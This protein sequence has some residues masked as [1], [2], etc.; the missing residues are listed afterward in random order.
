MFGLILGVQVVKIAEELV[1]PV[2]GRSSRRLAKL[3]PL[4]S[5]LEPRSWGDKLLNTCKREKLTA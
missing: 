4:A 2:N 5:T 1:E 3:C